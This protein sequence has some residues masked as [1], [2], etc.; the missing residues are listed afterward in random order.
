MINPRAMDLA[1]ISWGILVIIF[2]LLII[3]GRVKIR[4]K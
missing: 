1:S 3:A 2:L 4:E